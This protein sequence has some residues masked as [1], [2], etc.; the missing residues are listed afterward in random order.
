V[1]TNLTFR[2]RF[3][4][5]QGAKEIP[6]NGRRG[7]GNRIPGTRLWAR[8]KKEG[9]SQY[10]D[11]R[12]VGG[13][14]TMLVL[15]QGDSREGERQKS[16]PSRLLYRGG[17]SRFL[18]LPKKGCISGPAKSKGGRGGGGGRMN[19]QRWAY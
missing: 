3:F 1:G 7:K 6:S 4:C 9:K 17:K 13:E 14:L 10:G 15:T 18:E 16:P 12:E 8:V 19:I 11:D 5:T 2:G